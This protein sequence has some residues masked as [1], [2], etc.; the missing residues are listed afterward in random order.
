MAFKFVKSLSGEN[1]TTIETRSAKPNTK[2]I[3]DSAVSLTSGKI[4]PTTSKPAFIAASAVESEATPKDM[5]VYP[6]LSQHVYETTF[7]AAATS[8][9]IGDKVT[10][11]ADSTQVTAT[12]TDGVATVYQMFGTTA[13]SK[14]WVRFE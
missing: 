8:I 3:V 4:G 2:I 13:G 5:A 7:S 14:V 6:V 10:L 9:N 11:S 12:T 1:C